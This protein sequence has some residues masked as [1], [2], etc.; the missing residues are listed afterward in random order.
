MNK[1]TYNP[2]CPVARGRRLPEGTTT[3]PAGFS[4]KFLLVTVGI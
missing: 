1:L 4:F 2:D 3:L